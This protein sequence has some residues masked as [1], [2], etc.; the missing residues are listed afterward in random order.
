MS[1]FKL[2]DN[3]FLLLKED[4]QF[5]SPIGTLYFEHY[6]TEAGLLQ[7]LTNAKEK[8]QC[9]V[10]SASLTGAIPFGSTQVPRLDDYADGVDT[11]AFLQ[12]L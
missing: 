12:Q 4:E 7:L 9:V 3:N 1:D 5:A 10:G 6:E 8:I 11:V 2:L